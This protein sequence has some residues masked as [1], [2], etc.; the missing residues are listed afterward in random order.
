[1]NNR[2][3][4][5]EKRIHKRFKVKRG[6]IAAV[7]EPN[8][9]CNYIYSGKVIDISKG[10][11]AFQYAGRN[12]DSNETYELDLLVVK[13]IVCFA[14]L[15]RIPFKTTW[16]SDMTTESLAD[17]LNPKQRGVQFVNLRPD[18]TSNLDI[19]LRKYAITI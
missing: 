11:L 5:V 16:I 6:V 18:Q 2:N 13:D 17:E 10:G 19:F 15:K 3:E 9:G 8:I 1:M 7:I 12:G 4:Y 14:Y